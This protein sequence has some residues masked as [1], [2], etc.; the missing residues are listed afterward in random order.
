M[1]ALSL[2]GNPGYAPAFGQTALKQFKG[3]KIPHK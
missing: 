3:H 1:L 2:M